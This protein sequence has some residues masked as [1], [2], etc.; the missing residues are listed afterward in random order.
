MNEELKLY[1]SAYNCPLSVYIDV[2]CDDNLEKLIISG[3]PSREMLEAAKGKLTQEFSELSGDTET[4]IFFEEA[5]NYFQKRNTVLG[6]ELSSRLIAAGKYKEAVDYLSRNGIDSPVPDNDQQAGQLIKRL[7]I[8]IKN[9]SVK[10]LEAKKRYESLQGKGEKPTRRYYNRLLV[11]LSTCE[12]IKIQL[13]RNKLLLSE[14]AEYIHLFNE[15]QQ[16]LKSMRNE[17]KH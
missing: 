4:E 16:Q 8:K 15:Y 9:L 17:R 11:I 1:D 14:F 6:I 13:D 2:V 5:R 7:N 12:A 3:N 10:L